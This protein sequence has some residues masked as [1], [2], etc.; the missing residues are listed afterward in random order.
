MKKYFIPI[1]LLFAVFLIP[2]SAILAQTGPVENL[3]QVGDI[4]FADA[5]TDLP[6]IIGGFIKVLLGIMGIIMVVLILYAGFLWMT[7]AGKGDNVNKAKDIIKAAIIGLIIIVAAY[8]ITS[9]VLS[10]IESAV[11]TS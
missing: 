5:Q 7:D 9:F 10:S 1:I 11:G 3:Q 6:S 2:V 4:A 8:A